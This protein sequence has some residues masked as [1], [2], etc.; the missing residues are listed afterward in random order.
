MRTHKRHVLRW[1]AVGLAAGAV[2]IPAAQAAGPENR[3]YYPDAAGALP[4]SGSPDD[5]AHYRG[6]EAALAPGSVS[7]DDRAFARGGSDNLVPASVSP[8]DRA[9]TRSTTVVEPAPQFVAVRS[10]GFDWGDAAIGAAFVVALAL[11]AMA[12]MLV[13]QR[14]RGA[15]RPA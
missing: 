4:A 5:R 12:A 6:G 8:D 14:R 10:S 9:F 1:I 11:L 13:T 3:L 15:L 7:P 2:A